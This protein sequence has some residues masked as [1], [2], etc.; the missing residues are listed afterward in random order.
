MNWKL[1]VEGAAAAAAGGAF[2]G[3][4]IAYEA[5]VTDPLLVGKAAA[6]GAL[7]GLL[8]YLTKN[9]RKPK[10]KPQPMQSEP[11]PDPGPQG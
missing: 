6:S 2:T 7:V 5:K 4:V 8:G 9:A 11:P 1:F 3:G 10:P